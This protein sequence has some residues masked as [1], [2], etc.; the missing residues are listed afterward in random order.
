M[1]AAD[2][3]ENK[4]EPGIDRLR[5]DTRKVDVARLRLAAIDRAVFAA[6]AG[7]AAVDHDEMVRRTV[8]MLFGHG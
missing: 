8:D 1:A 5:V 2:D 7:H 6:G 4:G 3:N